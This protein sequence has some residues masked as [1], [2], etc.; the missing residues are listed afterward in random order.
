[1]Q[2]IQLVFLRCSDEGRTRAQWAITA[3]LH[4]CFS[5]RNHKATLSQ[6]SLSTQPHLPQS[7]P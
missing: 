7:V 4:E 3:E 2:L 5:P 6:P 1:M